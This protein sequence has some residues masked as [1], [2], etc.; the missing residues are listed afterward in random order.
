MSDQSAMEWEVLLG[1]FCDGTLDENSAF[2]FDK[3]LSER[4]ADPEGKRF[5][6]RQLI[7]ETALRDLAKA[8]GWVPGELDLLAEL[9]KTVK[10]GS[11]EILIH[12]NPLLL[13]PELF[14]PEWKEQLQ[15]LKQLQSTPITTTISSNE[16]VPASPDRRLRS[17]PSTKS[18]RIGFLTRFSLGI[19]LLGFCYGIY[20]EFFR[21]VQVDKDTFNTIARVVDVLEAEWEEGS[22]S[23]KTGQNVDPNCLKLKS[24]IVKLRF[25]DGAEVV[26]E[27]PTELLVKDKRTAFCQHGKLS[28]HVPMRAI[29]FE[30]ASPLATVVDLGTE[31]TMEVFPEKTDVHVI[32]GKVEVNRVGSGPHL[33]SEGVAGLFELRNGYRKTEADP[34]HFFSEAKLKRSRDLYVARRQSVWDEQAEVLQKNPSL[35]YRLVPETISSLEKT[36]GSREGKTAVRFKNVQHRVPASVAGEYRNLTLIAWVRIN[37]LSHQTNTLIMEDRFYTEEGTF[38]WQVNK[39]G[40]IQFHVNYGNNQPIYRFDSPPVIKPKDRGTWIMLA[41]VTDAENETITHY[42]DGKKIA[43]IDWTTPVSFHLDRATLGN[44]P[45]KQRKAGFRFFNGDIE[46]FLIYDRPFSDTEISGIYENHF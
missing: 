11:D 14:L 41:L 37:S 18:D 45:P 25:A 10:I 34:E 4:T 3:L 2:H 27:G 31:F 44:E 46:D 13:P 35:I 32:K 39:S 15:Q 40:S 36:P 17:V 5:V 21:G 29:G 7:T 30:V 16:S 9:E 6:W 1:R 42:F 8:D 19:L 23:Y 20:C 24:G 12:D 43:S 26:L 28:V 22:E 38:L 33:L